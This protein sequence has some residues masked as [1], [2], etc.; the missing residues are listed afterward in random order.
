PCHGGRLTERGPVRVVDL[1]QPA[2]QLRQREPFRGPQP[3][4]RGTYPRH[5]LTNRIA[6]ANRPVRQPARSMDQ[7]VVVHAPSR[8][9]LIHRCYSRVR[10][11][12]HPH[13]PVES[14]TTNTAQCAISVCPSG[15]DGQHAGAG[16]S[17]Q[18]RASPPGPHHRWRRTTSPRRA[19]DSRK[20]RESPPEWNPDSAG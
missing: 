1:I 17:G 11:A 4:L 19:G 6:A 15:R 12:S 18:W 8:S 20:S 16:S 9:T 14:E 10:T 13:P 5:T 2:M 7:I 3:T